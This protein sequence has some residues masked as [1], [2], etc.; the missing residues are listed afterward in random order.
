MF[1][2]VND[3]LLFGHWTSSNQY[4]LCY[5]HVPNEDGN[6]LHNFRWSHFLWMGDDANAM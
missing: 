3:R 6:V 2:K 4:M 5:R 1:L